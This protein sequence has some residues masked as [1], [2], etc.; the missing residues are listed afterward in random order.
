MPTRNTRRGFLARLQLLLLSLLLWPALAL[1]QEFPLVQGQH[2][3]AQL[4]PEQL[5]LVLG[6]TQWVAVRLIHQERWHTY[7]LNPG[8]AGLPT[9]ITWQLPEGIEAGEIVWPTP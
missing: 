6:E 3:D 1:A 9:R 2:V 5:A 4:V 8:E 7:W